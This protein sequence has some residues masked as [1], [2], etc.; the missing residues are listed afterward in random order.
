MVWAET[1]KVA[2]GIR[3]RW[4]Y[5]WY[6][7][8]EGNQ[9]D[10][11][12]YKKNVKKDCV[13]DG[14]DTCY[15]ELALQAHNEKRARHRGGRPLEADLAASKHIQKILDKEGDNFSGSISDRPNP[16][17]DCGENVYK[18]P[19][20]SEAELKKVKNENVATDYW[21]SGESEY[22][23]STGKPRDLND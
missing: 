10:E 20:E 21:Y 2:F 3:G 12:D 5:A 6:C 19:E 13:K 1:T 22:D 11:E 9:G 23:Y 17:D 4:V 18:H 7:E 15:L 14:V 8:K 16:F